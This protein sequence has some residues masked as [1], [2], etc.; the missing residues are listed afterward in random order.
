[1]QRTEGE[2]PLDLALIP[3]WMYEFPSLDEVHA[4]IK[5]KKTV[6]QLL[7]DKSNEKVQRGTLV[8]VQ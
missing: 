8:K 7:K 4:K 2:T 6:I 1:M 5:N 3:K